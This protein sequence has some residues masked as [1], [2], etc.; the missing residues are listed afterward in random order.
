MSN[1]RITHCSNCQARLRTARSHNT[2]CST[3]KDFLQYE[4]DPHGYNR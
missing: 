1:D 4:A 2:L 3:C